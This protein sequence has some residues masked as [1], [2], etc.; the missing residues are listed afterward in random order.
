ML[1]KLLQYTSTIFDNTF[2]L[3]ILLPILFV[4]VYCINTKQMYINLLYIVLFHTGTK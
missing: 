2:F 1:W 3:H 4:I